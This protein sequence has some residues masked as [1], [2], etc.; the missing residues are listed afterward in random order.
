[1]FPPPPPP[2]PPQ[3]CTTVFHY[4]FN[5]H[6]VLSHMCNFQPWKICTSQTQHCESWSTDEREFKNGASQTK[7]SKVKTSLRKTCVSWKKSDRIYLSFSDSQFSN[8]KSAIYVRNV[9]FK[10]IHFGPFWVPDPNTKQLAMPCLI[11]IVFK[12]QNCQMST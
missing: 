11:R 3:T 9:I 6:N 4:C 10:W 8:S 5:F 12:S 7:H 2:P 1:M